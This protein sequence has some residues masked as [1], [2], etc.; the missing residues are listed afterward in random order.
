ML[1]QVGELRS[2]LAAKIVHRGFVLAIDLSK[3]MKTHPPSFVVGLTSNLIN[4]PT[5]NDKK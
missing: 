2:M 3:T 4:T 1:T 5:V